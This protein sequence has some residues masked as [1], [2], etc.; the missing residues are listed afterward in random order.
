MSAPRAHD[1][2][3]HRG[4]AAL[5]LLQRV[6][7]IANEATSLRGAIQAALDEVSTYMGWPVGHAYLRAE[8]DDDPLQPSRVWHLDDPDRFATF[9]E[10]TER[11]PLASGEGLPGRIVVSGRP[12]WISDVMADPNFPRSRVAAEIGVRGAFGFPIFASKR[13]VAVLEFFSEEIEAPDADVLDLMAYVGKQLGAVAE[14]DAAA[15]MLLAQVDHTRLLIDS[16]HDA[17]VSIDEH[18][19]ITGWNTAAETMFGWP[20]SE[21]V[22]RPLAET[23]VPA[24]YRAAHRAGI[25]RFL[26]T[27]EGPIL[28]QRL[29]LSAVR[30]DGSVFPIEL[31]VWPVQ[32]DGAFT[33]S[34][35]IRDITERRRHEEAISRLAA[36]V[37]AS[38]DAMIVK[39][40][41]GTILSWNA[42]AERLYGYTVE[43]AIGRPISI[44]FP[45]ERVEELGAIFERLGRGES[46]IHHESV[47]RAKNGRLIDVSLTISPIKA[48]SGEVT[49]AAS[50]ARDV[51]VRR[52]AERLLQESEERLQKAQQIS[53]I[54][55]WEWDVATDVVAWSP[56][57]YRN[58]GVAEGEF[59]PSFAG[60]LELVDPEDR[61]HV[62]SVIANAFAT[63][64]PFQF[65]HRGLANNGAVRAYLCTGAVVTS[66][67]A[68]VRMAGTN[69]D[70]TE[71]KRA[72]DTLKSAFD[73]ERETV[74]KLR[75]LDQAKTIFISS[76][77]HELRTPLTSIVGY[78]GLLRD[79][80]NL[81]PA[82]AEML[83]VI[84]RNSKRLLELIEDLLTF[85]R[86]ESGTFRPSIDR[87][88]VG[89][90]FES[91]RQGLM[92]QLGDGNP[93][94]HFGNPDGLHV[95]GDGAQLERVLLNLLSNAMKFTPVE[96]TVDVTARADGDAMIAIRVRDTGIGIPPEELTQ[97][98]SP[99]FRASTAE[100][101]AIPGTGLGL[102]IVKAIVDG[103]GGQIGIDSSPGDGT[104]VTI[105]IPAAMQNA[106]REAS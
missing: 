86:L 60:Y 62:R 103:H 40:L 17:F 87:V 64:E 25:A 49:A 16:A 28:N 14:R 48:A 91:V 85:S 39:S 93:R 101:L 43:E 54:G 76:V 34:A 42:G 61:D 18:G 51:S 15:A 19:V 72:E 5:A 24:E 46:V 75:E 23:I 104:V 4:F 70:I 68:V 71:R 74:R 6:A 50:I 84:D 31:A 69:E 52:R 92:P 88:S 95:L 37:E 65:V 97:I 80:G 59:T 29:E 41:D 79:G 30:R 36:I 7:V 53:G 102:A 94:I 20:R 3:R 106:Q 22:G 77:S 63:L 38:D 2:A 90:L 67:D 100:A 32:A 26:K 105:R 58:F 11:M 98:F 78:V 81:H 21:A 89:A 9:R 57:L 33:F 66:G 44:I 47:Q 73:R 8:R 55:S 35:F 56:Q 82:E 13:V 99:F 45:P 83:G 12:A 10:V 27:R 96:G 1:A